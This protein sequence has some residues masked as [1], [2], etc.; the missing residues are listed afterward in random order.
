[1]SSQ[2]TKEETFKVKPFSRI[3]VGDPCYFNTDFEQQGTIEREL[4]IKDRTAS[5][6]FQIVRHNEPSDFLQGKLVEYDELRVVIAN[7]KDTKAGEHLIDGHKK[8][9][10]APQRLKERK[11]LGCDTASFDLVI[12]KGRGN[13]GTTI[14]TGADGVYGEYFAYKNKDLYVLELYLDPTYDSY[15]N[16]KQN[17]LSLFELEKQNE[18]KQP[19]E[20]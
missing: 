5:V 7:G 4:P 17:I 15:G 13:S 1:M 10:Y 8:G 2:V 12:G 20:R 18:K 9:F 19:K 14:S 3:R 6:T 11:T 16:F